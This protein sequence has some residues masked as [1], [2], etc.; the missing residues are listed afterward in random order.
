MSAYGT[1]VPGLADAKARRHLF[2]AL[3]ALLRRRAEAL[4]SSPAEAALAFQ[5]ACPLALR[6]V[7]DVWSEIRKVCARGL[8]EA[9]SL[10][11]SLGAAEA[12]LTQLLQV[13]LGTATLGPAQDE[14][15]QGA[16]VWQTVEGAL[17]ALRCIVERIR[18]EGEGQGAR[19][20]DDLARGG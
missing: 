7:V 10:S 9:A 16:P 14:Q 6:G 2:T 20:V 15:A 19:W 13:A 3:L 11:I 18:V 17:L 12:L 8:A 1:I 4:A 5:E